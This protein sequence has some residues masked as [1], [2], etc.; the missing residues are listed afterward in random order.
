MQIFQTRSLIEM[1]RDDFD[2]FL[3]LDLVAYF[4]FLLRFC[5][6]FLLK[7]LFDVKLLNLSQIYQNDE[8]NLYNQLSSPSNQK[9][10]IPSYFSIDHKL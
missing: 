10:P 7:I 2:M 1:I 9:A 3:G 4:S 8:Q 6:D 5:I